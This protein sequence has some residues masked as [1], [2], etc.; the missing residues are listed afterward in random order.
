MSVKL[1][2][3]KLLRE[4]CFIDGN[5]IGAD[6]AAVLEV[7]NPATGQKLGSIPNMG[8]AETRRAIAAAAAALPGWPGR[9]AIG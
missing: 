9:G 8:A 2:D 5:W 7:R 1:K 4:L 3:P 6:N